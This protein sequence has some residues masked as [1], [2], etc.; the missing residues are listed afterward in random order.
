MLFYVGHVI[1]KGTTCFS[2]NC[3]GVVVVSKHLL[4]DESFVQLKMKQLMGKG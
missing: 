3:L 1:Y 4:A 2:G